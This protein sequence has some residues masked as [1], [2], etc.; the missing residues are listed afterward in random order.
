MFS[1]T[2]IERY[3]IGGQGNL[4]SKVIEEEQ[5]REPHE[6]PDEPP[7]SLFGH[8]FP[9]LIVAINSSSESEPAHFSRSSVTGGKFLSCCLELKEERWDERLNEPDTEFTEK[10]GSGGGCRVTQ[11]R[12]YG[13]SE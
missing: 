8:N 11:K 12:P 4:A 13:S 3:N 5:S 6:G 1:N 2:D 9:A 10:G 7:E